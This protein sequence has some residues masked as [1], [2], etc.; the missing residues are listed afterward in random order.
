MAEENY[1]KKTEK[2]SSFPKLKKKKSLKL[3]ISEIVLPDL[4]EFQEK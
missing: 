2:K 1:I 3:K 4:E